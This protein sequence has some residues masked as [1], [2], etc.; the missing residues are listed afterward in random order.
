MRMSL[1]L[2]VDND[3][4]PMGLAYRG[5]RLAI[6]TPQKF[7]RSSEASMSY[8]WRNG[9]SEGRYAHRPSGAF[10]APPRQ[11]LGSGFGCADVSTCQRVGGVV[12]SAVGLHRYLGAA[13]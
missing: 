8:V 6:P 12:P 11:G 13:A 1:S 3:L 4:L 10:Y 7:D 5:L 2:R 9:C